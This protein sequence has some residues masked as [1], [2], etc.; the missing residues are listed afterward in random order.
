[1]LEKNEQNVLLLKKYMKHVEDVIL[2][3]KEKN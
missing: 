3:R 2:A 1:M